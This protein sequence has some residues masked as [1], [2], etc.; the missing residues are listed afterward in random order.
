MLYYGTMMMRDPLPLNNSIMSQ[1]SSN[2]N[3][4]PKKSSTNTSKQDWQDFWE[5]EDPQSK[6]SSLNEYVKRSPNQTLNE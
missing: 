2:Q 3:Q 6:P 4:Q 1:I 5:N